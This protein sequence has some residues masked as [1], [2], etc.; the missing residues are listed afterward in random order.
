MSNDSA[1]NFF[2]TSILFFIK[3]INRDQNQMDS[4]RRSLGFCPQQEVLFPDLSVREHILFFG[5][6]RVRFIM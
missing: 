3:T 6:I 5:V 4:I 2:S 1:Q